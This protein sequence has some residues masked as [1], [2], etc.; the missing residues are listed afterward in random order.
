MHARPGER[1]HRL[2]LILA[3]HRRLDDAEEFVEVRLEQA[4]GD[5]DDGLRALH[6]LCSAHICMCIVHA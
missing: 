5:G 3:H 1:D 2:L 4:L 6:H